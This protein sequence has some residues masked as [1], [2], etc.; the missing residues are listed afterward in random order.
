MAS[1]KSELECLRLLAT[2]DNIRLLAT[3]LRARLGIRI[4]QPHFNAHHVGQIQ[5]DLSGRPRRSPAT[6]ASPRSVHFSTAVYHG[7]GIFSTCSDS[8]AIAFEVLR[9]LFGK[10][11]ECSI[12]AS[13]W[14]PTRSRRSS[15]AW[16][17][18]P[19]RPGRVSNRSSLPVC[20]S[21]CMV[22]GRACMHRMDQ[23]KHPGER[24]PASSH[25]STSARA[26]SSP[27]PAHAA[28][29]M[30]CNHAIMQSKSTGIITT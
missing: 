10:L 6:F 11:M 29:R 7:G 2:S 23:M 15:A 26:L 20:P 5:I 1:P 24:S 22:T 13:S 30:A 19:S 28:Y 8:I 3:E 9:I 25:L 18:P 21:A 17:A 14:A 12:P 16:S 27:Q 4:I